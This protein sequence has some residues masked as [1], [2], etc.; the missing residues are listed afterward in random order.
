[1]LLLKTPFLLK[2]CPS[3]SGLVEITAGTSPQGTSY[4]RRGGLGQENI[5][6]RS[7]KSLAESG[8]PVGGS[9]VLHVLKHPRG[10]ER[11]RW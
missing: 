2:I 5:C 6:W 11:A 7:S 8:N 10:R 1:M 9:Q 4:G 3:S